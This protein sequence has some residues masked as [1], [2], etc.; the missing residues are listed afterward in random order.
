MKTIPPAMQAAL[1]G[2]VTTFARCVKITRSDGLVLGFTEHDRDLAIGGVTYRAEAALD[3][4]AVESPLGLAV[5]DSELAGAIAH[6]GLSADALENRLFDAAR[7]ELFLTD[8]QAPGD[9]IILRTGE[10][11]EVRREGIA[12]VAELRGLAHRLSQTIGRTYQHLCDA[13]LG[14]ARCGVD[15]LAPAFRGI[16]TVTIAS[17]RRQFSASG[18]GSHISGKFDGG[19]LSWTSGANAGRKSEVRSHGLN[20]GTA[21]FRLWSDLPALPIAGDAFAVTAG[22]TKTWEACR[23]RFANGA[24]FRG[25]PFMP[26]NDWIAV[27]PRKGG[28]NDGGKR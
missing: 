13:E 28:R 20:A 6:D 8:W 23:E 12:F 22:C 24:N 7:V 10:L 25:F 16:G 26:G 1:D 9:R 17:S 3:A 5:S 27:T 19:V 15:L 11:G 14:D 21:S 2:G 18:L 4:S